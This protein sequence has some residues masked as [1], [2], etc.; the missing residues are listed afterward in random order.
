[1]TKKIAIVT[2]AN[3]GIG[4]A[5]AFE[6]CQ[7]GM[8]VILASRTDAGEFEKTLKEEGFDAKYIPLDLE[9][10]SSIKNFFEEFKKS[11]ENLDVLVNNAAVM[12]DDYSDSIFDLDYSV[13]YKTFD[14]N[15]RGQIEMIKNAA[16]LMK[17]GGQIINLSSG[18]GQLSD[19]QSGFPAYRISKTALNAVTRIFHTELKDKGIKV[20]S[21][22][23]GWVKTRMGGESAPR[24]TEQGAATS[25]WLALKNPGYSGEFM[26]DKDLI[27]D[28]W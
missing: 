23:P 8:T 22:C 12:L 1:M 21:V 11:Y 20:N 25:V 7:N 13:L 6:L 9:D 24:T 3:R 17:D 19:M 10:L 15:L 26:R 2:G 4:E 27:K 5:T 14:I 16:P 18:A 28:G